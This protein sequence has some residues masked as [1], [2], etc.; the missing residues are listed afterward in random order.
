MRGIPTDRTT[1]RRP[2]H[3]QTGQGIRRLRASV[4]SVLCRA[5]RPGQLLQLLLSRDASVLGSRPFWICARPANLLLLHGVPITTPAVTA[6]VLSGIMALGDTVQAG[7]RWGVPEHTYTV[8]PICYRSE[9]KLFG[10]HH[11]SS[12]VENLSPLAHQALH[13]AVGPGPDPRFLG[14]GDEKTVEGKGG[15][16]VGR[17]PRRACCW[18]GVQG[19]RW[20]RKP[21]RTGPQP[22]S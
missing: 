19:A 3:R 22:Q 6:R 20:K 18:Q 21:R 7:W 4:C 14:L 10:Q 17:G 11:G 2:L 15:W 8:H 16:A 1:S 12:V 9:S 5:S 13:Y